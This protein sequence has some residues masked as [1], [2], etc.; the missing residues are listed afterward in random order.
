MNFILSFILF[1][2]SITIHAQSSKPVSIP[3]TKCIMTPPEGFSITDRFSGFIQPSTGASIM[4][5]EL[6]ASYQEMSDAFTAEALKPKGMEMVSKKIVDLNGSKATLIVV[7]QDAN[8]IRYKKQ[9]LLFGD[10]KMVLIINGIYPDGADVN[11]ADIE[12]S[13]LTAHID[14]KGNNNPLDAALFTISLQGSDFK[15]FKYISGVLL[16]TEDNQ[17]PT[18]RPILMAGNSLSKVNTADLKAYSISHLNTLTKPN[19]PKI[20]E[21]NEVKIDDLSGIEIFAELEKPEKPKELTY[22]LLLFTDENDY[23]MLFGSS[24]IDFPLYKE[25]YKKISRSFKR[26]NR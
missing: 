24:T 22:Q 2:F 7:T 17:T 9:M 16:Y 25:R 8:G 26:K 3:G 23:F 14:E 10:S 20:L 18:T 19:L 1:L 21:V 5:S 13:L 15:P 4:V 11:E 12:K 6:P